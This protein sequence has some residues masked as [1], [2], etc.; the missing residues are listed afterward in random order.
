MGYVEKIRS[1]TLKGKNDVMIVHFIL[2]CK[3]NKKTSTSK[4]HILHIIPLH[5]R[6]I[7][8]III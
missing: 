3:V 5:R 4:E 2:Y 7:I 6:I 8:I 1:I